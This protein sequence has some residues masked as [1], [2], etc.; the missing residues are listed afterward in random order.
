MITLSD[1]SFEI[2]FKSARD[3][4]IISSV[5]DITLA[6]TRLQFIPETFLKKGLAQFLSEKY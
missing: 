6:K 5:S 3:G 1:K 2:V 4:D